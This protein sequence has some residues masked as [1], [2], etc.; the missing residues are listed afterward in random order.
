MRPADQRFEAADF[1]A[2]DTDDR[3]IGDRQLAAL[4][5]LAKIVFEH[6]PIAEVAVHRRLVEAMLATAG[7]LGGIEREVGIADQAVGAGAARIADR[8]ADRR[9]DLDLMA[10]DQIRPRDLLDQRPGERFEEADVDTF[11]AAPP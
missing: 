7:T 2:G 6:L 10:L 5:R 1:L 8:D 3:L 9:A 4:D 11:R